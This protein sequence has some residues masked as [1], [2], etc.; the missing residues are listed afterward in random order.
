M[1][2]GQASLPYSRSAVKGRSKSHA[3]FPWLLMA[4]SVLLV[5]LVTVLPIVQAVS[6]SLRETFFLEQGQFIGADHYKRFF[7]DPSGHRNIVTTLV[8]AAGSIALTFPLAIGLALLL[9]RDF[10]GRAVVRT[11][12]ILPWVV[13]QLLGA[14]MWQWVLSPNIG[15]IAYWLGKFVGGRVDILGTTNTAMAGM[16][17][18][19]VWRTYPYA[20]ILTLAAIV[21]VP[22]DLY[23][24]AK[25]DGANARQRF[26]SITFP[27]IRP[28]LLIALIILTVN[29]INMIELPLILTG[30]GP[31]DV[32]DLLGLRVYREAFVLQNFGFASAIAIVMFGM[33][34]L[35][36]IAYIRVL[37]SEA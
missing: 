6:L 9:S 8:F 10:P 35:M 22:Q 14:L 21:T 37:R 13:S 32:T 29:A 18:A 15:A 1:T 28:T 12:L 31:I 33:N 16:I 19:N 2:V 27:L 36:S 5:L 7:A 26:F 17:V 24:A 4:P 30:G 20:M 23:E 11:L 3:L 25:V 34:A